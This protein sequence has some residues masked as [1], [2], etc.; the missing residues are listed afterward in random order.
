MIFLIGAKCFR[1]RDDSDIMSGFYSW[2]SMFRKLSNN[3]ANETQT[4]T[5]KII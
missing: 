2:V 1:P 3:A 4:M 5:D